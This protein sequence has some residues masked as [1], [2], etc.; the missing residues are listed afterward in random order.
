MVFI[1][2]GTVPDSAPT[3]G[4]WNSQLV[5]ARRF[6]EPTFRP[7]G[8]TNH[9]KK[10]SVSRLS[11]LFAHLHLLSSDSFSSTLLSSNLSLLSD[12]FH[13]CFS[14][15]HIVGSLTSKL[16][17]IILLVSMW[18][19]V[20]T[21]WWFQTWILFSIIYGRILPI[22]FHIFKMVKTTNQMILF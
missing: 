15:V 20:M 16:P 14:S 10:H 5:R 17:S 19:S 21:G 13:L 3:L 4:S 1:F 8:A 2:N 9:W 18:I 6:S 12:P 7:S 11:Y 22:D